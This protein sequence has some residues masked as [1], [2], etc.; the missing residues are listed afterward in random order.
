MPIKYTPST[1]GGSGSGAP[2]DAQ[3]VTLATNGTL[4]VERVLTAGAGISITDAGAGSH[5]NNCDKRSFRSGSICSTF[6]RRSNGG[7]TWQS[8]QV[9][10]RRH[11]R[12]QRP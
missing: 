7:L 12:G 4:T 6:N 1:S 8:H 9:S 5:S 2:V 10:W 11:N 3:Y